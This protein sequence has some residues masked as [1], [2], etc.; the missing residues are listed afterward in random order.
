MKISVPGKRGKF[1][2]VEV[3]ATWIHEP[4]PMDLAMDAIVDKWRWVEA[5]EFYEHGI[6]IKEPA[7][8]Y[9]LEGTVEQIIAYLE[10]VEQELD[11]R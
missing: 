3:T 11:I 2:D 10:I 9:C 1:K 7:Y 6:R 4:D 8:D 5:N